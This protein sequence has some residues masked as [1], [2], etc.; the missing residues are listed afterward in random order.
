[1]KLRLIDVLVIV[2]TVA[3]GPVALVMLVDWWLWAI[4]ADRL[5]TL[6]MRE[7][8]LVFGV[9]MSAIAAGAY[10]VNRFEVRK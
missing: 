6:G 3:L 5:Q 8:A 1:M 7:G 9:V 4:G 2:A 10:A